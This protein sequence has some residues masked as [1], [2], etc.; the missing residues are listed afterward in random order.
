MNFISP[1]QNVWSRVWGYKHGE[2]D[3]FLPSPA[4]NSGVVVV[5]VVITPPLARDKGTTRTAIQVPA[6]NPIEI[7]G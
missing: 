3:Y 2:G 5:V 7:L 1:S 6:V 4:V